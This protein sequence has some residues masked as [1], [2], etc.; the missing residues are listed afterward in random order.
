[1]Q[2]KK[3]DFNRWIPSHKSSWPYRTFNQYNTELN[4][5]IMS[6][7]SANKYVFSHLKD[8][9][10]K[11]DHKASQYLY[12]HNNG[13]MTLK[14]WSDTYDLFDNWNR[15]NALV[16]LLSYFETY[17]SS[18]VCLAFDSDPAL[19]IGS[20]HSVDGIKILKDGHI[21]KREDF[22]EKIANCTRGDWNSRIA[23]MESIFGVMP[24]ILT[25]QISDLEKMRN[26]RNK[27]GHAFGRDIEMSRN[28]TSTHIQSMETL[29]ISQFFKYQKLIKN[30]ANEIDSQL[31]MT[32]IGNFQPLYYYHT[33]YPSL[34][35][36][37][38]DIEKMKR[39]KQS[40]EENIEDVYSK[41]FC[42]WVISYY[43]NL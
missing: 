42:Q 26:L 17:I 38:Q 43:E 1:M 28:Y 33:I 25:N 12:T 29:S 5:I 6:Y 4:R 21:F 20:I 7:T 8:D 40:I 37:N 30:I 2:E 23:N 11:W 18:I 39:F 24:N 16:A 19:L 3:A 9:G 35:S 10:A 34:R 32:H 36:L 13:K 31:M 22:K 41:D 15:L 27:V 14:N